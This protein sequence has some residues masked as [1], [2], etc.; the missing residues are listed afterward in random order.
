MKQI[1]VILMR[2]LLGKVYS[3]GMDVLGAKLAKLPGVDYVSVE[4]YG[5]WRSIR[6][7]I[8]KWKDP[9]IVGGHSFGANAATI[10]AEA[11]P[12]IQFPMILSF[13]PSQYWSWGLWQSG[14]SYV[15]QNVG[16][17]VNYYQNGV[18]IGFQ[19]LET[20]DTDILNRLVATSHTEID[21]VPEL[22]DAAIAEIKKVIG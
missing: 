6:N 20:G 16:R 2:G 11:L 19:K 10:I 21:D 15:G 4:D 12:N 18:P 22:H 13:D 5:S 7:R 1:N 3:R 8:T 9:T 14:P 17:V